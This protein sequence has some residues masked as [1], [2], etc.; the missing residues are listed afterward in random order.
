MLIDK[1]AGLFPSFMS[2]RVSP[3]RSGIEILFFFDSRCFLGM[4]RQKWYYKEAI[5]DT[6]EKKRML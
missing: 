2:I 6:L 4:A 3:Y 1:L 5:S